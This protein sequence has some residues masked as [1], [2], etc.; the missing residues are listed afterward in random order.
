MHQLAQRQG[1][2]FAHAI[3]HETKEGTKEWRRKLN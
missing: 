2:G 1:V 3:K